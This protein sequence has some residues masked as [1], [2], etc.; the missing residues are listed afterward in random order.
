VT[1]V[2]EESAVGTIEGAS[3]VWMMT[4]VVDPVFDSAESG[5]ATTTVRV[6]VAV[7]PDW[8]VAT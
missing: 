3:V 8:S 5:A 4:V 2:V 7:R 6:D 1:A